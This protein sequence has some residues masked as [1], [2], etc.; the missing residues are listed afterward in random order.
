MK[1]NLII[2]SFI[3]FFSCNNSSQKKRI[4]SENTGKQNEIILVINECL[5]INNNINRNTFNFK[6]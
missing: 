5:S 4:L 1:I 6:Y 2:L 3:V